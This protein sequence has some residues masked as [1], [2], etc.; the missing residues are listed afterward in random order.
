MPER[1]LARERER[2]RNARHQHS[3]SESFRASIPMWDSSDP[4]RAPPPLPLNPSSPR[5]TTGPNTSAVVAAAAAALTERARESAGPSA[6]TTNPMPAREVSPT[7][8]LIKGHHHKRM[9]SLQSSSGNVRDISN[10][11]DNSRSRSD[12]RTPERA[13]EKYQAR[14]TTPTTFYRDVGR[15][16]GER[17][18]EK[19]PSRAGT[20]SQFV[21]GIGRD[22]PSIRQPLRPAKSILGENTPPTSATMLAIQNMSTPSIPEPPKAESTYSSALVRTPQTFDALSTQILSLTSIATNLQREMAQLSRRSKDNATDL[23]SLKEATQARDEDIRLSLR[24]L[25]RNLSHGIFTRGAEPGSRSVHDSNGERNSFFLDS[26]PHASPPGVGIQAK[27]VLLPRIPSPNTFAVSLDREFASTPHHIEGTASL[28][29]LEKIIREMGTKEGQ[30]RLLCSLSEL[31]D[32]MNKDGTETAK[33]LEE[34]VGFLKRGSGAQVAVRQSG[35]V[36]SSG[37]G[38]GNGNGPPQLELNLDTSQSGPL[39]KTSK[40]VTT[41]SNPTAAG[42]NAT[43]DGDGRKPFTSPRAAD[44]VGEDI[45]KV[46]RRL[47]DSVTENGG[48]TAEVKALV[49]ELR[50]EVLGMG[51]E[52]GRK[53]DEAGSARS[54]DSPDKEAAV[55]EELARIVEEGLTELKDHMDR[56]FR[57]NRRQ[58]SS[59]SISRSTVDAQEIYEAVKHALGEMPLQG[60]ADKQESSPGLEKEDILEAVREAWEAYKPEI[61]LQNFG[62]EREEILQCLREGLEQ[63]KPQ[64]ET[65]EVG[66]ISRDEVLEA[67]REALEHFTPPARIETEAGITREEI[68]AAVRECLETFEFPTSTAVVTREP[69]IT[70]DDL[71]D[72]VKEGLGTFEF[73]ARAP[74]PSKELDITRGD[75]LDAVKEGLEG[76]PAPNSELS[77]Q[78]L[79]KLQEVFEEMRTEFKAVSDE[80]KQNVAANGRDTEQV[81]DAL[82]DGL[83]HLRA[84]IESYVD[85]AADIT[86]RDEILDALRAGLD[87]VKE[88]IGSSVVRSGDI[89]SDKDELLYSMREGLNSLRSEMQRMMEKPG[90]STGTDEILDAINNGLDTLRSDV[91]RI[92]DK[93]VDM[94]IS[95]EILDTL[96]DGVGSLRAD[97]S[98]LLADRDRDIGT[99]IGRIADK[100]IDMTIC[101]E[102]LDTL[103]DGIAGLRADIDRLQEDNDKDSETDIEGVVDKPLDTTI[104]YEILDTL[105]D[106][107]AGLRA[108]IDR[109]HSDGNS[110]T[111]VDKSVD[112]TISYEILDTLKDGIAGLRADIDRLQA[113]NGK[114]TGTWPEDTLEDV[115]VGIVEIKADIDGLRA[116]R[117][118]GAETSSREDFENLKA[119]VAGIRLDIDRLCTDK[120]RYAG[121]D[122]GEAFEDLK[123]GIAGLKADIDRL[124]EDKDRNVS[125]ESG[126]LIVADSLRRDDIENL[127]IL[128]AQLRIKVES[129]DIPEPQATPTPDPPLPSE[130]ALSRQDLSSLEEVLKDVQESVTVIAGRE[131][132]E[133]EGQVKKEDVDAIETLLRNTK[134][135]IDEMVLPDPDTAVKRDDLNIVENLVKE[136]K[137]A[138]EHFAARTDADGVKKEDMSEMEALLKEVRAGLEEIREKAASDAEAGDR[139]TKIDIETLGTLCADTNAKISDL[140]LPDPELFPSKAD[141][142]TLGDI[143][144][145]YK[146]K[147]DADTEATTKAIEDRKLENEGLG[148]TL[149]EVKGFLADLREELKTKLEHGGQSVDG[150]AKFLEELGETIDSNAKSN[151]AEIRELMEIVT[152]EFERCHGD[153]EDGKLGADE[154]AIELVQKMEEARHSLLADLLEKLDDRFDVIVAKYEDAQRRSEEKETD[155]D[156]VLSSTRAITEELKS[157]IQVLITTVNNT[158][159]KIGDDS[160]TVFSRVDE[161]YSRIEEINNEAKEEH[162]QTRQEIVKAL[163]AVEDLGGTVMEYQPKIL[164]TVKDVLLV[165]GQ[166]YEQAQQQAMGKKSR[167]SSTSSS[168]PPPAMIRDIAEKYDDTEIQTK[169]DRLLNHATTTGKSFAQ[170]DLLDQIHQQVMTTAA[171]VTEF[172]AVQTR[173]ITE[174]HESRERQAEEA[175]VALE[176]RLAQ[177]EI[178]EAEVVGLKDESESLREAVAALRAEKEELTIQKAKLAADVSGLETAVKLRREEL[179]MMESRAESLERRILEG[180]ID[181]SRALL[182]SR[183]SRDERNM[184][185]KRVPNHALPTRHSIS[186]SGI[187][188]ALKTRSPATRLNPSGASNPGRRILSLNQI[189]GNAPTG[190]SALAGTAL[191]EK[192]I[193]SL[194]RSQSV[195][196]GTSVGVV[197]VY[198]RKSSWGNKGRFDG[199]LDKENE[200]F[201]EEDDDSTES[202]TTGET[203]RRISYGTTTMGTELTLAEDP[204]AE[205]GDE[206]E[207]D[208]GRIILYTGHDD[209]DRDYG[210]DMESRRISSSTVNVIVNGVDD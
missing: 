15:E 168:A 164:N 131:R 163:T 19:S 89:V 167:V 14:S 160:K 51:R 80:A 103:K 18:P 57:E 28:A 79:G 201:R 16:L 110:V 66:G 13:L 31:V 53:L 133:D 208:G 107:I 50:G 1:E 195:R 41:H 17:S 37:S 175:A 74:G 188:M 7:K 127:E 115:R 21:G 9:Q 102:I 199:T 96:K 48:L 38:I 159:E 59:S 10:S 26:A 117:D 24:E 171:E 86:G 204:E 62:L 60:Q 144:H 202:S 120:D 32:K 147:V 143:I 145:E 6:Y 207:P 65:R 101:Y 88:D 192:G 22:T 209:D 33:K 81:L 97:I 64:Q 194:K 193:T 174:N 184:S 47:K 3:N 106:G 68:L 203:D 132:Q 158:S 162:H 34:I 25:V 36:S 125:S 8:G 29:M 205:T 198:M 141:L 98:Q 165:V 95:Y 70:R 100:P 40:D 139:V 99:D 90:S 170:I 112:M 43:S 153:I 11:I 118:G 186:Q 151:N 161:T 166:H 123:V 176:K 182:I 94:T 138:F 173:L 149:E 27:S 113:E 197:G 93:P 155:K 12:E 92:V 30:E 4:V 42:T 134:A 136:I 76:I 150:L 148:V 77:E 137:E 104:S 2:E 109:L 67:V 146:G 56:V 85:R 87:H 23:I 122:P 172:V 180:V 156:N 152:R 52:I 49:R 55:K 140:V 157:L 200:V 73:H 179:A 119:C 45:L 75:V 135:K 5:I 46:L 126:Q 191:P 35:P 130:N 190:T 61:E 183:P 185:L 63:Y 178:I 82:K 58:S 83:E 181:H 129:L 105:K 54:Q 84:D 189:T 116:D 39:A 114:G 187:G 20:P 108:D 44:F 142:E 111:D 124:H 128:I 177:K 169:L 71:L 196:T 78:V 210:S 206:A 121:A 154:K 69:E 72:A 91:E